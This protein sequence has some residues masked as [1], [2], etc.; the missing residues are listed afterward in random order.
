MAE[1]LKSC[2]FCGGIEVS[3]DY[4]YVRA[5]RWRDYITFVK[6]AVCGAQS[7]PFAFDGNDSDDRDVAESKA[8]AAWNRRCSNG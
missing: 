4:R 3:F 7:R 1:E 6:C 5:N 8:M 2:P